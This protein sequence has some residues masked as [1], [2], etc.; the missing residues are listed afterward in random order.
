MKAATVKSTARPAK[1]NFG[2]CTKCLLANAHSI[3]HLPPRSTAAAILLAEGLI[4]FPIDWYNNCRLHRDWR[5]VEQ[6]GPISPL[7]NGV[8]RSSPE[9]RRPGH[10]L[11]LHYASSRRDDRRQHDSPVKMT[12]MTIQQNSTAHGLLQQRRHYATGNTQR[13]AFEQVH[14]PPRLRRDRKRRPGQGRHNAHQANSTHDKDYVS[15][16]HGPTFRKTQPASHISPPTHFR[17]TP[18]PVILGG[19]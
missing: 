5:P 14:G 2:L 18:N 13:L 16:T 12:H 17:T 9:H 19:Q 3:S 4:T 11:Q 15:E 6:I 1:A 8:D 7:A 10:Y